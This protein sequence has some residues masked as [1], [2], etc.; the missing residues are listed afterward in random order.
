MFDVISCMPLIQ[1]YNSQEKERTAFA[2][3]SKKTKD[4]QTSIQ[5]KMLVIN[6]VQQLFMLLV[7]LGLMSVVALVVVKHKTADFS[8]FLVYFYMLK[9]CETHF[10][11]FNEFRITL[12]NVQGPLREIAKQF[13]DEDKHAV[14]SGQRIFKGLNDAIRFEK[15]TFSYGDGRDVIR[16]IDLVIPKEKVTAIVGH[17][18]SGKTTLVNLLMR[19]YDCAGG[20]LFVDGVD[21]REIA[22]ESLMEHIALVSQDAMLLN[23][24]LKENVAYGL[25]HVD[26]GELADAIAKAR[27][28]EYVEGLPDGLDT[29]IGDRGVQLSGGEKQRIMIARTILKKTDIIILDEAT[30]SLDSRTEILIQE[31]ISEAIRGKTTIVIAH[32]LSTIRDADKIVVLEGGRI[33]EEGTMDAL[34]AKKGMF[35]QYWKEQG[36]Y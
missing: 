9:K 27:L 5:Q 17:T 24:S 8:G 30:S 20:S 4:L 25:S 19:F 15:M 28:K 16:G 14:P 31:S 34:L 12:A 10:G 13:S 21:I 7:M 6:P 1:A 18:G 11:A 2:R 29:I 32:R 33:V 22:T 23:A 26:E 36:F 3:I 35:Y